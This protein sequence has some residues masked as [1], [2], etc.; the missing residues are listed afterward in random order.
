MNIVISGATSMLGEAVIEAALARG[1]SVLA[2]V[3]R[4]SNNLERLPDSKLITLF[5]ADMNE[6]SAIKPSKQPYDVFFHFA[7]GN[8]TKAMRDN[9][10]LQEKNVAYTLDAIG[11]AH[12]LGCRRFVLAGS[13]AEYGLKKEIITENT[14]PDP[15]VAYGMAKLAAEMLGKK[16]CQQFG[17]SFVGL[18]IFSVYGPFDTDDSLI[19]Y[20]VDAFLKDKEAFFSSAENIWNFLYSSDA[21]EMIYRLGN[22]GIPEGS[23]CIAGE[24]SYPLKKYIE[25][26]AA[27]FYDRELHYSYAKEPVAD[28]VNL[29]VDIR[30]V[31]GVTGYRPHVA[32]EDGIRRVREYRAMKLCG[33]VVRLLEVI[34]EYRC[35]EVCYA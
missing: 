18:R 19:S 29:D 20:A 15:V 2:I 25:D 17:I 26:I 14:R 13:Q 28:A 30:K 5:Q 16:L 24:N 32:F 27:C 35:W 22:L 10:H 21:G 1:D 3:R 8:T 6:Y 4:H 11:L 9:P 23:Y 31:V 33:G 12:R 34:S 7:W